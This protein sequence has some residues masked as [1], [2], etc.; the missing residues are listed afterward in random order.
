MPISKYYGGHG[1]EVMHNM[2]KQYG[3]KKGKQ[4][5]YATANAKGMK[6]T[7]HMPKGAGM[8]PKGDIGEYRVMEGDKAIKGMKRKGTFD[9]ASSYL[10]YRPPQTAGGTDRVC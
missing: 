8:S 6:P 9:K 3:E 4:V 2:T 7:S 1:S 5:F 10:P